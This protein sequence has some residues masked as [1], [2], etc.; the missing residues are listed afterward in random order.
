[1]ISV[2]IIYGSFVDETDRDRA[3]AAAEKILSDAGLSADSIFAEFQRQWLEFDDYDLMHGTA[4]AWVKAEQA[5]NI[6]LTSG[7]SDPDGAHC[8]ISI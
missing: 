4:L 6:A 2:N 7:W 3:R 5:A 1:M 8:S